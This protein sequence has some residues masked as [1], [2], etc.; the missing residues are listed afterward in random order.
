MSAVYILYDIDL[1][2]SDLHY[3]I[4]YKYNNLVIEIDH[5]V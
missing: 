5:F 3:P 4:L 1:H 2:D